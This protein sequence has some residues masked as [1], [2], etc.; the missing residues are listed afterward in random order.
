MA[1]P[2]NL[3]KIQKK[4]VVNLLLIWLVTCRIIEN[5]IS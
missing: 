5:N 2:T 4:T 1:I 3:V